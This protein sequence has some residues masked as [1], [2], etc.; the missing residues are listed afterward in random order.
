MKFG[1]EID[2]ELEDFLSE[3]FP[4][5]T[6]VEQTKKLVDD[7]QIVESMFSEDDDIGKVIVENTFVLT[8]EIILEA[9]VT[10]LKL[11]EEFIEE[12]VITDTSKTIADHIKKALEDPTVKNTLSTSK[13]ALSKFVKAIVARYRLYN[14][15][16][17]VS[18]RNKRFEKG[19]NTVED[20]IT[21]QILKKIKSA[22]VEKRVKA[23][24][25]ANNPTERA[26]ELNRKR[27]GMR[28]GVLNKVLNIANPNRIS[29]YRKF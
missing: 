27:A 7:K 3:C 2:K 26:Y 16:K 9:I 28:K 6:A 24:S 23:G 10:E 11:G 5:A 15:Q 13:E 8:D 20:D 14:Q 1:K 21:A 4:V 19:T 17:L 29:K 12:N 18:N 22:Y 25:I